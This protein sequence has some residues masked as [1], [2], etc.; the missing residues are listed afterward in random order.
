MSEVILLK[1]K[2]TLGSK[3][4]E[5]GFALVYSATT[6]DG[7]EGVLKLIPKTPGADRELLFESLSGV[8]NVIPIIDSGEHNE[9]WVIAMPRAEK[10]L[11]E[12]LREAGGPLR[13]TEVVEIIKD[14]ATALKSLAENIVHRDIKPANVLFYGGHWCL[15]DF[16]IARYAEATTA[17]DTR[18]R[19]QS[20]PYAAPERWRDERATH[21]SD[22]YSLGIMAFELAAGKRPFQGPTPD[23]FRDQHLN[24]EVP[25]IA[26]CSPGISD[27]IAE[28][29][30]KA[31]EARPTAANILAR[32]A[33]IPSKN[34]D[35]ARKL[36]MA[37]QAVVQDLARRD[38]AM[39][40]AR[41]EADRR[42][43][44]AIAARSQFSRIFQKLAK[45]ISANAPKAGE[46]FPFRLNQAILELEEPNSLV[47]GAI[48]LDV[49]ASGKIIL[50][51]SAGG[52]GYTGRSHSI[53]YCDAQNRGLYRWYEVA[54]MFHPFIN[55]TPSINPFAMD[56]RAASA[57]FGNAIDQYQLAWPFTPI[58]QD[59]G[60]EFQERWLGWFGDAA[61]GRLRYPSNMP[62][63]DPRGSY[64]PS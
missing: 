11:K 49:I 2:W 13:E 31:R 48:H 12:H 45:L 27:L 36:Q 9:H 39:S 42:Q 38:Q 10:S 18:K 62:E 6:T 44:L 37:N 4:G 20:H 55:K 5:G 1:R 54:F 19:A 47:P 33:K 61:Q 46:D 56:P 64:R 29:L 43:E 16:G 14:V 57:A 22:I 41:T 8:P 63:R 53:W 28:C 52:L 26:G 25:E 35:G 50:R 24:S 59:E 32:L 34:S 21:A 30:L 23:L 17:P 60:D 40:A 7:S 51:G 15:A 3:I 58:D